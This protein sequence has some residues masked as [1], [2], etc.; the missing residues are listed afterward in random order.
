MKNGEA[1][2]SPFFRLL[3]LDQSLSRFLCL[4]F[5]NRD[6]EYTVLVLR[7]DVFLLDV[8]D[9]VQYFLYGGGRKESMKK[10]L[11][12]VDLNLCCD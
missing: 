3:D 6:I 5:G 2:A 9:V 1:T 11:V 8:A 4:E 7:L 12:L 10:D